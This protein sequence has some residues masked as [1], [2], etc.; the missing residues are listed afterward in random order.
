MP[1]KDKQQQKQYLKD[2]QKEYRKNKPKS[3]TQPEYYRFYLFVKTLNEDELRFLFTKKQQDCK[4]AT[5]EDIQRLRTEMAIIRDMYRI[6]KNNEIDEDL[7]IK[8]NIVDRYRDQYD[9]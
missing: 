6:L 7:D 4:Y 3:A 8:Y 1:Y 9:W 2:Y 5:K